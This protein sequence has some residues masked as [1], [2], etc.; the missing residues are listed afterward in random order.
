MDPTV[1]T[2][3]YAAHTGVLKIGKALLLAGLDVWSVLVGGVVG[4]V[5]AVRAAWAAWT[6]RG[7]PDG[8]DGS[9]AGGDVAAL[10]PRPATP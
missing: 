9:A 4:G 8:G 1:N 10:P 3:P 5:R 6:G 2:C 7:R